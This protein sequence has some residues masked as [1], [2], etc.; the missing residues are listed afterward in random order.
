M[1]NSPKPQRIAKIIAQSG[2]C[3][4]RDAEKII[5]EGR[6]K[7]N[8]KKIDS[9]ALNL[10]DEI[11]TIDD[12][13]IA[14]A[15]KPR[16]FLYYK[17]VGL[18]TTYR[19]E[20]GRETVFDQLPKTMPR[21]VSVGRLDL[22]SE[23]LLLLTTSGE[24]ARQF[25]L[26]SN[27]F[28]RVYRVRVFGPIQINELK[29]LKRGI[30]IDGVIYAPIDVEIEKLATNSWLKITLREGK[31]REIR[32]VIQHFGLEVSRL[33]RIEY[34]EYKL[35]NLKPGELKKVDVKPDGRD[36]ASQQASEP[37]ALR[38]NSPSERQQTRTGAKKNL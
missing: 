36:G 38:S 8:G 19:D 33:I 27:G 10:T 29:K 18:V 15:E 2:F 31:N 1:D 11:I 35:G 21:V 26:P 30:V 6:V 24:Q 34:G 3:S 5:A 32:K 16:L 25:E 22:N 14:N 20:L 9:P 37:S 12:K 7:V 23:G 4:R 13:P 28:K 17:P